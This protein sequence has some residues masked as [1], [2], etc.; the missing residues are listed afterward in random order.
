VRFVDDATFER[1][2]ATPD[3]AKVREVTKG[4]RKAR[5]LPGDALP[6]G[7]Y[8]VHPA[9][10]RRVSIVRFGAPRP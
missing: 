2:T 7:L 6:E 5:Y 1:V 9:G 10:D 4:D 3:P 8:V